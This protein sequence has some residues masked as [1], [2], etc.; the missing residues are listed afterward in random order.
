LYFRFGGVATTAFRGVQLARAAN[1]LRWSGLVSRVVLPSLS[2]YAIEAAREQLTV[3]IRPFGVLS[4]VDSARRGLRSAER[5][6]RSPRVVIDVDV[7]ERLL[8]RLDPAH[9]LDKLAR[10]LWRRQRLAVVRGAHMYF[11]TDLKS[12]GGRGL[13]GVNLNTGQ[14]ER[15]I[16]I[17]EPDERLMSDEVVGLL[18]TA[19]G[20]RL[21]AYKLNTE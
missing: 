2:D 11:Y 7:E 17:N 12:A 8:D 4:R 6:L 18:Y 5:A 1:S 19:Q 20:N 3:Q 16:R 10:F 9:Q 15:A 21:L 13:A 14:T